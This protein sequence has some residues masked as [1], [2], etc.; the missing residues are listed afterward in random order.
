MFEQGP[1][2]TLP[3]ESAKLGERLSELLATVPAFDDLLQALKG[4]VSQSPTAERD[5]EGFAI[6]ELASQ[7]FEVLLNE[8]PGEKPRGN[9]SLSGLRRLTAQGMQVE[10]LFD[11]FEEHFNVPATGVELDDEGRGPLSQWE[12][13]Q[14]PG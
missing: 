5:S 1:L 7:A 13:G 10:H 12:G 4:Q 14:K 6:S 3:E 2:A 11:T 9:H 8:Q